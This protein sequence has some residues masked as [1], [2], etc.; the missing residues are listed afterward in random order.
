[1]HQ[2]FLRFNHKKERGLLALENRFVKLESLKKVV[3]E[4]RTKLANLATLE[5]GKPISQS[6]SEVDKSITHIDY[7]IKNS[8]KFMQDEELKLVSGHKGLITH[9]PLG[10]ILGK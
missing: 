5:M 1:M 8:T 7:Y 3:A 2:S 6:L 10:T 9:Q 4:N